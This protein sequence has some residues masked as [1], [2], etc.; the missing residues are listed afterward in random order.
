MKMTI[1]NRYITMIKNLAKEAKDKNL[2]PDTIEVS[3]DELR[4]LV[5]E[6]A[7][8][9]PKSYTVEYK[10][11]KGEC[12]EGPMSS[13]LAPLFL[14]HRINEVSDMIVAG[15]FELSYHDIPF[16]VREPEPV[17]AEESNDV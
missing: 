7:E 11:R 8:F 15:D 5:K 9:K 10:N 12:D 14:R 3:G 2:I 4:K 6:L 13:T 16:V 17:K 1:K